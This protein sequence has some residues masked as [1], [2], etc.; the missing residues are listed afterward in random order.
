M[1]FESQWLYARIPP[2]HCDLWIVHMLRLLWRISRNLLNDVHL[3]FSN[4]H[5][6][7][8]DGPYL[9]ANWMTYRV[10]TKFLNARNS[11]KAMGLN[12]IIL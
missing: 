1:V 4:I 5:K 7:E 6:F 12:D 8:T 10:S 11:S 3:N 9:L 2:Y